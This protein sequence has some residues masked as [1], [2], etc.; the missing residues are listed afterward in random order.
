LCAEEHGVNE[1]YFGIL[2]LF[3][4]P[5]LKNEKICLIVQAICFYVRAGSRVSKKQ[6]E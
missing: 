1:L 4:S 3:L 6:G 5:I 2:P